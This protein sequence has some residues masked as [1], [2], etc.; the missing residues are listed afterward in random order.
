MKYFAFLIL[1]MIGCSKK[2]EYPEH[3]CDLTALTGTYIGETHFFS[4]PN[5]SSGIYE[6]TVIVTVNSTIDDCAIDF[7]NMP[8]K[9][10]MVLNDS[11]LLNWYNVNYEIRYEASFQNGKLF[12]S[13][14]SFNDNGI[15]IPYIFYRFEG[16]K[17]N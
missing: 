6:D 11:V 17:I 9:T 13:E 10:F 16:K 3:F 1:V 5:Q 15:G 12:T 14:E 2:L 8:G 7:S 4:A